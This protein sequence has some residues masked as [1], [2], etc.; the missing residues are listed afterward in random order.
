MSDPLSET[1]DLQA[2]TEDGRTRIVNQAIEGRKRKKRLVRDTPANIA[3][4]KIAAACGIA[5]LKRSAML[6][7][8]M[9]DDQI[10]GE[11]GIG[12]P[13]GAPAPGLDIPE[14][15]STPLEPP[16]AAKPSWLERFRPT[17]EQIAA[18]PQAAEF[19]QRLGTGLRSVTGAPEQYGKAW[20]ALRQGNFGQAASAVPWQGYAGAGAAIGIPALLSYMHSKRR[21][22]QEDPEKYGAVLTT[23]HNASYGADAGGFKPSVRTDDENGWSD[24]K[25]SYR[26]QALAYPALCAAI[27]K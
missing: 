15:P 8:D 5:M 11:T 21:Q 17:H 13:S 26:L 23:Y 14:P 1:Q 25:A 18:H 4:S 7:P 6:G 24:K 27:A 22:R 2:I 20:D 3:P 19:G 12:G 10:T 16:A 9:P